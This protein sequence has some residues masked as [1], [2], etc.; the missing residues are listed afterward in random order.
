MKDKTT[1]LEATSPLSPLPDDS[2]A[3]PKPVLGARRSHNFAFGWR[4]ARY[5]YHRL[6]RL[7]STSEEIARGLATGVFFGCL[8]MFGLQI[9]LSL[10]G[11]TLVRGS[12]IAAAAA[13]WVSNPFTYV[14]LY[15]FGFQ[16]GRALLGYR[17]LT[18]P[19]DGV[20][21]LNNLSS[22]GGD[23][24]TALFFGCGVMGVVAS[25]CSYWSCFY[26]V[27]RARRQRRSTTK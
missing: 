7:R 27:E 12:R 11:A 26:L 17:H 13:T 25:V 10:A 6:V 21:S 16:V 24:L 4:S 8:P 14:P 23:F 9:I 15:A 2:Q 18:F 5:Y 19:Q 22:L 3:P 1:L 20:P